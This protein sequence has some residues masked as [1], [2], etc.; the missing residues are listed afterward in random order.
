MSGRSRLTIAWRRSD[1]VPTTAPRGKAAS[2]AAL[3]LMK[4][5]RTSSRGRQAASMSPSGSTVGMSLLECTARSMPPIEQRLLDL[6]GEQALAADL[7]R[8]AGPG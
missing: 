6:L 5:S 8:A 4:A 2:V 3:R 7:G 1:A